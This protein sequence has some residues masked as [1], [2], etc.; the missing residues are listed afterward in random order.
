MADEKPRNDDPPKSADQAPNR[1]RSTEEPAEG[2][3][4]APPPEPG[5]PRSGK[6]GGGAG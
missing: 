6:E 4:D 5:S 3:D 2:A 1:G